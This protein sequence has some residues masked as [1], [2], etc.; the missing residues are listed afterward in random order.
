M[1]APRA[2][3]SRTD[4]LAIAGVAAATLA[5]AAQAAAQMVDLWAFH[6]RVAELNGNSNSSAFSWVAGAAILG[7]A[8][9][10]AG[11]AVIERPYRARALA[12]SA[13]FAFLV[14]DNRL[15]IH[16]RLP[17][18]KLLFLPVLGA[19]F[20]L[21]WQLATD[22]PQRERRLIR[23]GLGFLVVSLGIHL[24]GPTVISWAG[25]SASGWQDQLKIALKEATEKAGWIL[26]WFG[27]MVHL[28]TLR[29]GG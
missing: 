9:A 29:R 20:V 16:G 19:A 18:G 14:V 22:R 25:W 17:H 23:G 6:L 7:T 12:L 11:I 4:H 26:V 1:D 10:F 28:R 5:F 21:L 8:L 13:L 15:H 3:L 2:D 24:I 27:A